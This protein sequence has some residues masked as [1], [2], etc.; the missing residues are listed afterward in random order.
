MAASWAGALARSSRTA[1]SG[2]GATPRVLEVPV[3]VFRVD[4]DQGIDRDRLA[5]GDH[6]V[7]V[8]FAPG[9]VRLEDSA[10]RR[11]ELPDRGPVHRAPTADAIK[12]SGTPELI[13]H[14]A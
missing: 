7:E 3:R 2:M 5:T 8:D 9:R 11:D 6:G 13:Q 12:E 4:D 14:R 10:E 1:S